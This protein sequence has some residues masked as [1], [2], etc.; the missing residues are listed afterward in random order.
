MTGA[1]LGGLL[2]LAVLGALLWAP[3]GLL[4]TAAALGTA[5]QLL[6]RWTR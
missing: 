3:W 4:L 2:W 5:A 1:I 6:K